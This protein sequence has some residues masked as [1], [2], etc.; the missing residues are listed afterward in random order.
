MRLKGAVMLAGLK[1]WWSAAVRM[2]RPAWEDRTWTQFGFYR[3]DRFST[4]QDLC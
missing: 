1:R 2:K 4:F 3:E